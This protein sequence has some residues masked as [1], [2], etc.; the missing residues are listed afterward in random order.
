MRTIVYS[1]PK[2]QK[3]S[4]LNRKDPFR[5]R[6]LGLG[7]RKVSVRRPLICRAELEVSGLFRDEGVGSR[8]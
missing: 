8:G 3:L 6:A 5:G 2:V 4:L 1:T 7:F